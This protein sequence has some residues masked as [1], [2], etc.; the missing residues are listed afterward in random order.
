MQRV[1]QQVAPAAL[2]RAQIERK[3]VAAY[4]RVSAGG[5]DMLH[6]L[7]A[8]IS[9][10]SGHIQKNP[11]W[12][13][14][15]VFADEAISG[16]KDRR[17]EFQKLLDLCRAGEIDLIITKSVSRFA[18][19]TLTTLRI[20]REL[21]LLGVDVYFEEQNIHTC[22]EDGEFLLTLLAAYAQEEAQ[23]VS[24]NQKWR[25]KANFEQG[26]PWSVT[27][28]GYRQVNGLLEVVP[29]EAEVLRLAADL[30]LEGYGRERL[31]R[32]LDKAGV[33]GRRGGR[34]CG[35]GIVEL[36][37]NEKTAGD[38]LLQKKFVVDPISKVERINRGEL[39]Q[40]FVAG[41][42]EPII[43]RDTYE[44]ILEERAR[45]A[46]R[47]Q[48]NPKTPATYP[49]SGMITCEKCG[50]RFRRKTANA[51]GK[52][53]KPV[54]ICATFNSKGKARCASRQIPEGI[55]EE[56]AA[57]AMGLAEFD[58]AA[59]AARVEAIRVPENGTLVFVFCDGHEVALTWENPSRRQSWDNEKRRQA[60][61]HALRGAA[62]RRARL[63][64]RQ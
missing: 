23:S 63:C 4:A 28:F 16:T 52:Y 2:R 37:C 41:C 11:A 20:V 19:N 7:S 53:E 60:R 59:F 10:Y 12:E 56:V 40:Y 45:R 13:Y 64:Q 38:L 30:Y 3:R 57:R 6:S 35:N 32:A 50:A 54:W 15:G 17:E 55:L 18:R 62:E 39:P 25:I 1:I 22:G 42:H 8:Q 24:E 43:D 48:P 26:L 27:M 36:L 5:E 47:Y 31:E 34:M 49:F 61:E 14:M 51:G 44:R 9:Y 21:R 29:E 58:E 46:A 33:R